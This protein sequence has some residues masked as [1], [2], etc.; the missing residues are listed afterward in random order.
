MTVASI[1]DSY[2][3]LKT[4]IAAQLKAF[5]AHA[6]YLDKRFLD[7]EG[8]K[9]QLAD[10]LAGMV[11]RI[12]GDDLPRICD[13]YRWLSERVLEEE[14]N[15]RRTGAY[16][17]SKFADA[18]RDVYSNHEYMTRYM[19]GLLMSQLWWRNHTE[20]LGAFRDRFLS[21]N[22]PEYSH[23]EVG[24]GHGLF[25][26]LA[27]AAPGAGKVEGWD[28]SQASLDSTRKALDAMGAR[29]DIVLR[30]VDLF[31]SPTGQFDSIAFSEVLEHLEE[32][33]AALEV[34]HRLLAP[35]GR[36]FL[37]A[38]VNSPAPDHIYLFR[39]PEEIE[40][41]ARD[42][43]FETVETHAFPLTGATLER[44]RRLSLSISSVVIARK[45][46]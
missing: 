1:P 9:L 2:G 7:V 29:S 19:N 16:R 10:D 20:V 35:G 40:A 21:G 43:G 6:A 24:P 17:L 39:A 14:L 18:L 25:L 32:P 45:P 38:P 15:F 23:L 46:S 5:P 30:E 12:A 36:L 41:M 33:R 13:D 4:A 42:A 34:L 3:D 27:S 28:I 11:L 26:H 22:S 37:N 31:A 8:E 44:A